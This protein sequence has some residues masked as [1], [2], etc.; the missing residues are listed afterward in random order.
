MFNKGGFS[1]ALFRTQDPRLLCT[2]TGPRLYMIICILGGI[3]Q[4]IATAL[5]IAN[6]LGISRRS[7]EKHMRDLKKVIN[8]SFGI[9]DQQRFK[10]KIW[11]L[12]RIDSV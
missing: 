4:R 5:E 8:I 2:I 11:S 10:S 3:R 1:N 9:N 6:R 7:A 12:P